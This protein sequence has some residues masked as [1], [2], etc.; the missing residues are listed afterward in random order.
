VFG[1]IPGTGTMETFLSK[2]G[3][4]R[5][6]RLQTLMLVF[7]IFGMRRQGVVPVSRDMTLNSIEL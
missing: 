4:R 3:R 5:P 6:D 2:H 7:G 1:N